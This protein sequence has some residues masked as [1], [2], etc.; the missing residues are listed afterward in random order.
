MPDGTSV[1]EYC[2]CHSDVDLQS[3]HTYT[4]EE[5]IEERFCP[6]CN[7]AMQT[8]NLERDGIFLIERCESCYGLFFDPNELETL[9]EKSVANVHTIDF[10]RMERLNHKERMRGINKKVRWL[11]CPVCRQFMNRKSFGIRSGVVVDTCRNHG[12]WLEAAELRRLLE[13]K[14]AGGS[15]LQQRNNELYQ[16]EARK[17]QSFKD[18]LNNNRS[19]SIGN[20]FMPLDRANRPHHDVGLEDIAF[21]LIRSFT[22][23]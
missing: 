19:S 3:A 13:W 18:R 5:P 8:L 4:V 21:S 1:C 20:S 2:G 7:E 15:I 16:Q 23:R 9:L 10:S 11:K 6:T 17:L 14:K 12:I 22:G